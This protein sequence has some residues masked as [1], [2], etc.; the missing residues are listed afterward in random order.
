MRTLLCPVLKQV[1]L[2]GGAPQAVV[3]LHDV[4]E[5]CIAFVLRGLVAQFVKRHERHRDVRVDELLAARDSREPD[6]AG[7]LMT[8]DGRVLGSVGVNVLV[9]SFGWLR[10]SN[11]GG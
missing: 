3:G 8:S 7:E 1:T 5:S 9:W 10:K 6:V 2:R 4:G 11:T